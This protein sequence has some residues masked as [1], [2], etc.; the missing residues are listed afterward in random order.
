MGIRTGSKPTSELDEQLNYGDPVDDEDNV[1]MCPDLPIELFDVLASEIKQEDAILRKGRING[2]GPLWSTML[3]NQLYA[4]AAMVPTHAREAAQ[5]AAVRGATL[6]QLMKIQTII[7]QGLQAHDFYGEEDDAKLFLYVRATS[8]TRMALEC[9]T[10]SW[11]TATFSARL[12]T[13][14]EGG[15]DLVQFCIKHILQAYTNQTA[16]TK[17]IGTPWNRVMM[18]LGPTKLL[19]QLFLKLCSC[20]RNLAVMATIK[21]ANLALYNLSRY[22]EPSM[23]L[24]ATEFLTKI[25][26]LSSNS[27]KEAQKKE[28]E[29]KI[30]AAKMAEF[31]STR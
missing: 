25:A 7:N 26:I 1:T 2:K 17:V 4:L 15:Y 28:L 3:C 23:R 30:E 11:L 10:R 20:E 14:E 24:E 6:S 16:L 9:V 27:M 21:N 5:S 19:S 13:N 12:V 18:N 22:G 29:R 31:E 8:V